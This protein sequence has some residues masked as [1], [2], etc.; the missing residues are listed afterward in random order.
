MIKYNKSLFTL[1]LL[2]IAGVSMA[3]N[4]VNSPYTRY[5]FGLLS[6]QSTTANRGMGGISYGLRNKFINVG[7]PAS[8]SAVDSITFLFD[9]GISL[10][11]GN[12]SS[13][14]Q[15]MNAKNSS[16]DY[17]AMQFRLY[18]KVGVTL[19]LLPFSNINY[20]FSG[21][22]QKVTNT[23]AG[24]DDVYSYESFSGDGGLH[25]A[26]IGIGIEPVKNF[27]IGAN[28]SYL[29]GEYSHTI[30]NSYSNTS[31][32]S[33]VRNYS[34]DINTYKLDLGAQYSFK[35]KEKHAFTIGA[36]YSFGHDIGNNAYKTQQMTYSSSSTAIQSK[37]DTLS[38]AFELP[39]KIGV[40]FTYVY[41][42]RL[43]IGL[44]YSLQQW[45]SVKFP[46][47]QANPNSDID[48]N[49]SEQDYEQWK[50]K[51]L[52]RISLGAEYVPNPLGR[53][54]FQRMRY[55]VGAYYSTPY[56][57]VKNSD[58]REFGVEGGI[59][60]P[61]MNRYNNRSL[62]SITA[63]YI[64]VTP[65]VNSFIKENYLR[66]NIGFTFNEDWFR[67]MLVQ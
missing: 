38:N 65:K 45:S 46:H 20:S 27:S 19:G 54:F 37:V 47:F 17:V 25:Q 11:N 23:T 6:D 50:F 62:L 15:K 34:A 36:V 18:R 26:F 60:I 12:F 52:S 8:Y 21:E 48:P 9:V 30:V 31:V 28:F 53:N 44:D 59:A 3:Q 2:M 49:N 63:Q 22:G 1:L 41:D 51:N 42:N 24:S 35:L 5:G 57:Q 33:N 61:I 56:I 32:W 13:R 67:K 55:R 29:Y 14:N 39:Q 4:G 7:N 58:L 66:I 10:Q 64:N 40:G 16:L 43:T